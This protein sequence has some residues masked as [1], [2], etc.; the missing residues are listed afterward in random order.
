MLKAVLGALVVIG[1][2]MSAHA[3]D[4]SAEDLGRRTIERRAIEAVNWGIPTVHYDRMVQAMVRDA[5]GD[6]N[7]I[8]Y[9]SAFLDAKNQALTIVLEIPPADDGSITGT[10]MDWQAALED[11]GPAGVDRGKGGKYLI[12]PPDFKGDAPAGYMALPSMTYQGCALLRSIV[13]SSSDANVAKAVAYGSLTILIQKDRPTDTSNWLPAP[14]GRF[15]LTMRLYGPGT[16]VLDG[17]D[18]LPPVRRQ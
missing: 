10:I 12:L 1:A 15:N 16:P 5:K 6:F 3:Q 11:V 2:A 8:V 17:S 4:F 9:W 13:K 18:R 14:S 7:Q